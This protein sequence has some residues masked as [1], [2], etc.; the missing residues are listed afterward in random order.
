MHPSESEAKR[1]AGRPTDLLPKHGGAALAGSFSCGAICPKVSEEG[2]NGE[3][4]S[5][6]KARECHVGLAIVASLQLL[7]IIYKIPAYSRFVS[8]FCSKKM[9]KSVGLSEPISIY[10][11]SRQ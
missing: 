2:R 11:Y 1:K 7:L 5:I 8:L 9:G 4:A 6:D 10:E 3:S